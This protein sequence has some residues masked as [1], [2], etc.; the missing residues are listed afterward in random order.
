MLTFID[1][2]PD[3]PVGTVPTT[4]TSVAGSSTNNPIPNTSVTDSSAMRV[5]SSSTGIGNPPISSTAQSAT[6]PSEQSSSALPSVESSVSLPRQAQSHSDTTPSAPPP[7]RLATTVY[8]SGFSGSTITEIFVETTY[9]D[10]IS[11]VT[12]TLVSTSISGTLVPIVIGPSGIGWNIPFDSNIPLKPPPNVPG[13]I[14]Q[15]SSSSVFSF[16]AGGIATTLAETDAYGHSFTEV[17]TQTTYA[18]FS[19]ITAPTTVTTEISGTIIPIL[20][21]AS[22]VAWN[23]PEQSGKPIPPPLGLPLAGMNFPTPISSIQTSS[24]PGESLATP[25]SP[26]STL[27]GGPASLPLFSIFPTLSSVIAITS[28]ETT[29]STGGHSGSTP[30][31]P[32]HC[33][34]CPPKP[35][36][37][38]LGWLLTGFTLPGV[39]PAGGPPAGFPNPFPPITIGPQ[40][41][42]TYS[43]SDPPSSDPTETATSTQA[44]SSSSSC[45]T[46]TA[47]SC[48]ETV[49][50]WVPSGGSSQTTSTMVR[51]S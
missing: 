32:P 34:F 18:G 41:D 47:S 30:V 8:T 11:L 37:G 6:G 9:T 3:G 38:L 45:T 17:F 29:Y 2:T 12:P 46:Q 24:V 21:G 27:T 20:V 16:S 13:S 22:G 50:V 39:Y 28:G 40:G 31:L 1:V 35:P 7:G 42:P 51:N 10:F 43:S 33:W 44:S 14:F 19:S 36:P 5:D 49:S 23:V 4:V 26:I 25:P 48:A 15:Q